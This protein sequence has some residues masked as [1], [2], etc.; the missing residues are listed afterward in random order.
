MSDF[1]SVGLVGAAAALAVP[2]NTLAKG[3]VSGIAAVY[4]SLCAPVAGEIGQWLKE[5]VQAY[6]LQNLAAVSER[7]SK[8]ID[9]GNLPPGAQAHPRLMAKILDESS[10]ADDAT[11]Q[12]MWAGLLI[13]S[14]DETG[15]DDS[16]L[17]F[18]NRL[19]QLTK[20]QARILHYA[21][22]NAQKVVSKS[23]LITTQ[24]W[25]KISPQEV[26]QIAEE[27]DIHRLDRECDHLRS[28][29]L[30]HAGFDF[31]SGMADITPT[32][33]A[34]NLF[35]RCQGSRAT[36]GEFFNLTQA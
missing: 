8:L 12:D 21:C 4:G 27:D 2:A 28:L 33:L 10:W 35:V 17:V 5:R 3:A 36:P 29:E 1:N 15:K 32:P 11:V 30:I 26:K 31:Y 22:L 13:S 23:G 20:V 6:R 9:A 25:L 24:G 14:C 7:T 34:L 16:N 18:I 19:S